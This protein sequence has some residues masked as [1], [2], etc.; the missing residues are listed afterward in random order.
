LAS[1]G[2]WIQLDPRFSFLVSESIIAHHTS[3][4][5]GYTISGL[6]PNGLPTQLAP[7]VLRDFYQLVRI[8]GRILYVYPPGSSILS[9]PFVAALNSLGL[10]TCNI[11]GHFRGAMNL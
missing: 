8:R 1:P 7:G 4:L 6:N 2:Q 10:S 11:A 9:L 5:N 3:A